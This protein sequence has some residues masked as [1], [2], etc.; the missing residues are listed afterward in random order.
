MGKNTASDHK[1]INSIG[2]LK[3][4]GFSVHGVKAGYL[5]RLGKNTTSDHVK[6]DYLSGLKDTGFSVH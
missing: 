6:V 5:V 4:T 2:G 3:D 1:K